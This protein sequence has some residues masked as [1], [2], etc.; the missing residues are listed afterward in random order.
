MR[1]PTAGGKTWCVAAV[2]AAVVLGACLPAQGDTVRKRNGT[3]LQGRILSETEK[4]V[5]FE[6]TQFGACIVKIPRE[7]IL[8]ITRGKYDPKK[9]VAPKPSPGD[10]SGAKDPPPSAKIL[11]Y[12]QIPITGEIGIELK[13][14]DFEVIVRNVEAYRAE[15]LVL[16][17]DSP[18]GSADETRQI[19]AKMARLKG[20]RCVALVKRALS[21][22]AVL[23]MACPEVYML[24]GGTIGDVTPCKTASVT[25]D[26]GS[27][28]PSAV[29][30]AFRTVV[31]ISKHSP[32]LLDGM[33]TASVELSV[34]NSA[35]GSPVVV[36][37]LGGGKVLKKKGR[38]LTLTGQE[39]VDC[40]LAVGLAKDVETIKKGVD[41][42]RSWYRAWQGGQTLI[43]TSGAKG[44]LAFRREQYLKSIGP[45]LA[46]L[47]DELGKIVDEA[48]G[49][50]SSRNRLKAKY[51]AENNRI[52]DDY[53]RE[54]RRARDIY[55]RERPSSRMASDDPNRYQRLQHDAYR[56]YANRV[57]DAE[58]D[59][60]AG[61]RRLNSRYRSAFNEIDD[62]YRRLDSQA[63]TIRSK[64]KRL[65]AAGPK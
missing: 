20:V 34:K 59:R 5:V 7:Q 42:D 47:D 33:M 28:F 41:P 31:Q 19:L 26:T 57:D 29:R 48:K 6:W 11:R 16:V 24:E 45:E 52:S 54:V 25:H 27:E 18:G 53:D 50:V 63:R 14:A 3:I 37:G 64:K 40:G 22:A 49:L 10:G 17:F 44:R 13:A 1:V 8:D 32:L 43:A 9:P 62:R 60:D 35:V 30:A 61:Y 36:E 2:C 55:D 38:V 23:A 58:D 15:V 12:C 39:A 21:T 51:D 56:R 4:E 65:L 46:K